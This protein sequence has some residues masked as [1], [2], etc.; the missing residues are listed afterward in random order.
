MIIFPAIDLING[1]CVRLEK[2][3]FNKTTTYEIKPKDVAKAYQQAG[4][5]Y[6]HIVDLDG[7]KQGQACQFDTIKKI[8]ENCNIKLQVGGGIKDFATIDRLL[9]IGVDRVVIGSLAVKDTELT[10]KIFKKY[11]NEKIVL[12][13]DVFFKDD[14]F[15]VATHGWQNSSMTTLNEIIQKYQAS[16]LKYVLCT[17]ISKDGMLQGPNFRLYSDY[18]RDYPNIKIMASGGVGNLEDLKILKA[19]NIYGVILGKALYENRFTLME[20]LAC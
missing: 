2:G 8:R 1:K 19:Q 3:N 16:D 4:A 10:K 20:A 17:D 14:D 15:Y 7:A 18:C 12:A 11:G 6:I 9:E 13:L 5:E